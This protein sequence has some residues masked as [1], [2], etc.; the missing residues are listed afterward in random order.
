MADLV[1]ESQQ[2][3]RF[4]YPYSPPSW[5]EPPHINLS[6]EQ[7][8]DLKSLRGFKLMTSQTPGVH[9]IHWAVER[10]ME[11]KSMDIEG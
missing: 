3:G 10:L 11:N 7:S 5:A 8:K 6:M 2:I 4:A 9:C 1:N